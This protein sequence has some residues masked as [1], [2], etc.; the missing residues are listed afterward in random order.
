MNKAV[1]ATAS[2]AAFT[3]TFFSWQLWRI[4]IQSQS[5]AGAHI[6][7]RPPGT[8][9][10]K[11]L[12]TNHYRLYY[13]AT[14]EQ[15]KSV[16]LAAEKLFEAYTAL[17][18]ASTSGTNEKLTL[19]LYRHRAEFKRNNKSRPWAEAFYLWPNCYAYYDAANPSSYHWMLHEATHQLS[20]EVSDYKRNLWIEEGLASHFAT[21]RLSEEK[22]EPGEIDWRTYPAWGMRA[23]AMGRS[24]SLN[25]RPP[26][27][28]PLE[29]LLVNQ[30]GGS[31]DERFNLYY[32]SAWSLTH[33]LMHF[34]GG[35][36][37][38][39]Y[40]RYLASSGSLQEFAAKIGPL[41]GI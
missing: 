36:Y 31:V 39:G 25:A 15:A 8:A 29:Q 17:F 27:L 1:V 21:S 6:E 5:Q 30:G 37:F 16:G 11:T 3:V 12:K 33:F 35:K 26:R 19:V 14:D 10:A 2:V 28:I 38:D 20:A 4:D 9:H 23:L 24:S 22:L 18:Q 34:E 32:L 40:K 13:T 7:T 41:G